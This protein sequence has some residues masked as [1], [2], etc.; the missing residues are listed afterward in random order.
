VV[1]FGVNYTAA[2]GWSVGEAG[3]TD[4]RLQ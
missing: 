4:F 2:P 3:E 1:K